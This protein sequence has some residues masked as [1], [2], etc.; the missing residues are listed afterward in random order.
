MVEIADKLL[1]IIFSLFILA[2]AYL[3]R[4][5][6]GTYIFPAAL[7]SLV[8][9]FYTFIPLVA[10]F[11]VPVNPISV[12]YILVCVSAFSL[13][14]L[15]FDW[16]QAYKTNKLK[17]FNDFS[18]FNSKFIYLLFYISSVSSIIFS[19]ISISSYGFDSYSVLFNFL[20]TSGRFAALRGQAS[21]EVNNWGRIAIFF[22]Y[23]TPILGGFVYYH[24]NNSVK[25]ITILFVSIF[26]SIYFMLIQ[27]SKLV[28]FYAIGFYC[29]SLLLMNIYRNKF[30]LFSLQSILRSI[31]F[32]LLLLPLILV[33]FLSRGG[34]YAF[35]DAEEIFSQLL[36]S[37]SSYAFA[38]LY[39]FSDFFSHYLG[40]K[41][42]TNYIDNFYTY[43]YYTFTSIFD[44]FGTDKILLPGTF[45][46]YYFYKDVLATNI[47]TI[48]RGLIYDFG[49]AGVIIFM[50]A[51]GFVIHAFFYLL[52]KN[53]TSWV[54]CIVFVVSIVFFQGTYLASIFMARFMYII[55]VSFFVIL[56]INNIYCKRL[57]Y[58]KHRKL[59]M[60]KKFGKV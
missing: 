20:E 50:F 51:I 17:N 16:A 19:T 35:E 42:E 39:A 3:I 33:S 23:A 1:A 21:I 10:L 58:Q 28:L 18:K 12:L 41:S 4:R 27:S 43:G 29:A 5:V 38:G 48:F 13:G 31:G 57:N 59:V 11:N 52:L 47:F 6:V 44:L 40:M 30:S 24:Q 8:W 26:P 55:L 15:P 14:S 22:T 54:A 60:F 2:Q 37:F 53:R 46:D 34:L 9:F 49:G 45:E 32:A 25:K 7:L 36:W 56:L